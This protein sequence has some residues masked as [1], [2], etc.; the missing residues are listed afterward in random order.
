AQALFSDALP[1]PG[2]SLSH[3]GQIGRLLDE[4]VRARAPVP[5]D[6]LRLGQKVFDTRIRP[7]DSPIPGPNALLG[8]TVSLIDIT[9]REH[10]AEALREALARAEEANQAKSRFLANV[11]HEIRTPLNGILGMASLLG[12]TALSPEQR[13]Y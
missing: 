13:D 10:A 6:T 2:E 5:V 4:V 8:W 1:C 3:L 12:E 11:S 7:I 9:D